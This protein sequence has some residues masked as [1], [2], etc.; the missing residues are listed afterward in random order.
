MQ[1]LSS[2]EQ[3]LKR[4]KKMEK[5]Q[6]VSTSLLKWFNYA[7]PD[8]ISHYIIINTPPNLDIDSI[9]LPHI[10]FYYK[11]Q[12]KT[13]NQARP[14]QKREK[15]IR[16]RI[17]KTVDDFSTVISIT[18]NIL[19]NDPHTSRHH[20]HKVWLVYYV[21]WPVN[22]LLHHFPASLYDPILIMVFL[23]SRKITD[24]PRFLDSIGIS[25]DISI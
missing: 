8:A 3:E 22:K 2:Y 4:G 21:Q 1:Y 16:W 14:K 11:D 5:I 25:V 20:L 23:F 17:K 19:K 7:G 10:A 24:F 9:N 12:G 13:T 18:F 6:Q 15:K